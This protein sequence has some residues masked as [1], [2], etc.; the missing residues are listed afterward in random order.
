MK[1]YIVVIILAILAI[2]MYAWG[3]AVLLVTRQVDILLIVSIVGGTF[4]LWGAWY[5]FIQKH[6][7]LF[8]L[9]LA[10]FLFS[11]GLIYLAVVDVINPELI[12]LR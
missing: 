11:L 2:V 4:S 5:A 6:M 10:S 8:F 7:I 1:R 3:V 9:A 12:G